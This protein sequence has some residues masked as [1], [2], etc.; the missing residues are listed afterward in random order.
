MK[1]L[2]LTLMQI[3]E[4][5]KARNGY[6]AYCPLEN[7]NGMC[8]AWSMTPAAWVRTDEA[9]KDITRLGIPLL[10]SG[11]RYIDLSVDLF[12]QA[13]ELEKNQLSPGYKPKLWMAEDLI[14]PNQLI[15]EGRGKEWQIYKL[16]ELPGPEFR[17]LHPE[18]YG[19]V[20]LPDL[21]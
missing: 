18:I 5:C 17:Y 13:C 20:E 19:P 10:K 8:F 4:F 15:S 2:N 21:F 16:T 14:R 9:Q 1:I 7:E 12:S 11:K 6:C 3:S